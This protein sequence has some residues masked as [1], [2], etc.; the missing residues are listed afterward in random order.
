MQP[1]ELRA[2]LERTNEV[3]I[4]PS[5]VEVAISNLRTGRHNRRPGRIFCPTGLVKAK[6]LQDGVQ[7]TERRTIAVCGDQDY[8]VK[9]RNG[10]LVEIDPDDL[11]KD[12]G[13]KIRGKKV[14]T[15]SSKTAYPHT[16]V[17]KRDGKNFIHMITSRKAIFST[18][19]EYALEVAKRE[20]ENDEQERLHDMLR[21][22]QAALFGLTREEFDKRFTASRK[23]RLTYLQ[24]EWRDR[25]K[26]NSN[27]DYVRDKK[28]NQPIKLPDI[29]VIQIT[30]DQANKI[31]NLLTEDQ[32]RKLTA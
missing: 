2:V 22:P 15:A 4:S 24:A 16:L 20:K 29:G 3:A 6:V 13:M 19:G 9:R 12:K 21:E 18:W 17:I 7:W 32:K 8:E 23:D 27:G 1:N 14:Y 25:Y 10:V 31:L 11:P 26:Y 30:I 5:H 28:T